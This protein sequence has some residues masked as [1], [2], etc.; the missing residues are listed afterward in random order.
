ML[1]QYNDLDQLLTEINRPLL[2]DPGDKY[3]L[4]LL[5]DNDLNIFV[6]SLYL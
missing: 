5:K 1:W 6:L 2:N 4:H 3:L